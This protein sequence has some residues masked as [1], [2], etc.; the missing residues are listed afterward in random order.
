MNDVRQLATENVR[1]ALG[2]AR[3]LHYGLLFVSLL[4]AALTFV[5][6]LERDRKVNEAEKDKKSLEKVLVQADACLEHLRTFVFADQ[7]RSGGGSNKSIEDSLRELAIDTRRAFVGATKVQ[8]FLLE[9]ALEQAKAQKSEPV[10]KKAVYEKGIIDGT[11]VR[12][13]QTSFLPLF[14]SFPREGPEQGGAVD[15]GIDRIPESLTPTKSFADLSLGD[16]AVFCR[17]TALQSKTIVKATEPFLLVV[18]KTPAA[19]KDALQDLRGRLQRLQNDR[20][21]TASRSKV[22]DSRRLTEELSRRTESYAVHVSG[23]EKWTVRESS[24]TLQNLAQNILQERAAGASGN[25]TFAVESYALAIPIKYLTVLLPLLVAAA[26]AAI[27]LY[28]QYA[29]VNLA[30]ID[31][32]TIRLLARFYPYEPVLI[33]SSLKRHKAIAWILGVGGTIVPVLIAGAMGVKF[34]GELT[35]F[36]VAV[37]GLFLALAI[38]LAISCHLSAGKIAGRI[39]P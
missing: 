37:Y 26:Y 19:W 12:E 8:E 36:F 15:F 21:A 25:V 2:R 32:E 30:R 29:R 3:N 5:V 28:L 14:D 20:D 31:D 24:S 16:I 1:L 17:Y 10:A 4:V 27:L 35:A 6:P 9:K 23:T 11:V 33:G 38:W 18:E 39:E 7:Q 22:E 34:Y 13:I